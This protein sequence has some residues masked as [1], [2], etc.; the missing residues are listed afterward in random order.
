MQPATA[1]AVGAA[2]AGVRV[3]LSLGSLV[4]TPVGRPG[5]AT[6]PV[7]CTL[8]IE[9]TP[10]PLS[11]PT[12]AAAAIAP[13]AAALPIIYQCGTFGCTLPNNHRGLHR[14]STCL[15]LTPSPTLTL[16]LTKSLPLALTLALTL[17]ST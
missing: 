7:R 16:A 6:S 4:I 5:F 3:S 15:T 11:P 1:Q 13:A 9:S 12:A 17:L 2:V 14:V 10:P 8:R